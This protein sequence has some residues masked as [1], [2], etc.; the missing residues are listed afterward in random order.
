MNKRTD[1]RN[2]IKHAKEMNIISGRKQLEPG[3]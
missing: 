1:T 2:N 3:L